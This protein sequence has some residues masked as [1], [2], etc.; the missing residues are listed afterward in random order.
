MAAALVAN[1]PLPSLSVSR[2]ADQRGRER[3]GEQDYR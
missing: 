3:P 2:P 1:V